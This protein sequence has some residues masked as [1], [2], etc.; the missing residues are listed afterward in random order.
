MDV[1]NIW[2]QFVQKLQ[3]GTDQ[4]RGVTGIAKMQ[5]QVFV[6]ALS[7]CHVFAKCVRNL[8][9]QSKKAAQDFVATIA[10]QSSITGRTKVTKE[11]ALRSAKNA[12]ESL[13]LRFLKGQS[14]AL[15]GAIQTNIMKKSVQ[16]FS[17]QETS[18]AKNAGKSFLQ[19]MFCCQNTAVKAVKEKPLTEKQKVYNLTV[20]ESHCYF[21]N[22]VLVH[23]VIS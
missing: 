15:N 2:S 16:R 18:I 14:I 12:V 23:R 19:R 7:Q 4:K 11:Q 5:K 10:A 20:E 22:G 8:F 9:L 13:I 21:A 6:N 1:L 3:N 17:G